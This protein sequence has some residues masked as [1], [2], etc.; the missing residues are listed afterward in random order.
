MIFD[1][2]IA[3]GAQAFACLLFVLESIDAFSDR[4]MRSPTQVG[5][6]VA[7]L[8]LLSFVAADQ[9]PPH[10]IFVVLDDFGYDDVGFHNNGG[11]QTPAMD[12][13]H[14]DG[15]ELTN[16]YVECVCSPTRATFMT[17]RYP[18]HHGVT[19]WLHPDVA[20][21]LPQDELTIANRLA[22]ANYVSHMVGKWHIGF[23]REVLTPTFRGFDSF[24]GFYGLT[25]SVILLYV[26]A[27]LAAINEFHNHSHHTHTQ[28]A[29]KTITTT[30][31]AGRTTGA[32]SSPPCA[33]K[34]AR[35]LGRRPK[36]PTA[37][38]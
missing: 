5:A 3:V 33:A 36:A 19:D 22:D 34:A 8:L 37:P 12:A 27:N 10:I 35:R 17:G 4:V 20:S 14:A 30:R 38:S 23:Y 29:G 25:R 13:L 24:V 16:Y 18:I 7:L 11:I 6:T 28:A 2:L 26:D 21:G 9:Q 32:K 15:I 1:L 31:R